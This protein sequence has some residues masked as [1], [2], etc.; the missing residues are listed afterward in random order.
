MMQIK[1]VLRKNNILIA[2]FLIKLEPKVSL[3]KFSCLIVLIYKNHF[4]K[5]KNFRPKLILWK[6]KKKKITLWE[7]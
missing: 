4:Y 2:S 5:K 3:C 6:K 7:F 1:W